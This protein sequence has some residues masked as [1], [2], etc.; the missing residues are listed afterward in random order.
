MDSRQVDVTNSKSTY[1][2]QLKRLDEL[3]NHG[4]TLSGHERNCAFLRSP[5]TESE[6]IPKFGNISSVSGFD[7]PDDAR[8]IALVDWDDDGD[9][10]V[11]VMNRTGPRLRFL[12]NTLDSQNQF[13][14]LQ[15]IGTKS[16]RDAIGTRVSVLPEGSQDSPQSKTLRAGEG[17][18]SQSSKRIHFGLGAVRNA[19]GF[20]VTVRWPSGIKQ[21]FS[22]VAAN[23]FYEL[24]EGDRE[25]RRIADHERAEQSA[26]IR[27]A[28]QAESQ[29][30]TASIFL[31]SRIPAPP[32]RYTRAQ[33]VTAAPVGSG[34]PVLINLWASWCVPC[35]RELVEFDSATKDIAKL[36][37][38]LVALSVDTLP[39]SGVSAADIDSNTAAANRIIESR[40]WSFSM[41]MAA[42]ETVQRLQFL[43]DDLFM[44]K[45][46]IAIP[47]SY[48]L[49]GE[50]RL[51]AIYRGP[52]DLNDLKSHGQQLSL[53]GN[54][55][56]DAALPFPGTWFRPV[57]K[58]TPIRLVNEMA[59]GGNYRDA[60]EYLL[61]HSAELSSQAGY[62]TLAGN[63]GSALVKQKDVERA[64]RMFRLAV[65][66]APT[67]IPV[68]NNLAWYLA[69]KPNATNAE[70]NEALQWATRAAVQTK[71][72]VFPVL[73]TLATAQEELGQNRQAIETLERSIN[74]VD[75]TTTKTQIRDRVK[76]LKQA[77]N[78]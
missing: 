69:T 66:K 41:G 22:N 20:H 15:L 58:S 48:L 13:I 19:D 7:F 2:Q 10:D 26:S 1:R 43:E 34:R 30:E 39:L 18:L 75:D 46:S 60:A 36:G 24:R 5:P 12:R 4:G 45:R 17:F 8:S 78:N 65:G 38:D 77:I 31:A 68:V 52:V 54:E 28:T 9:Q 55:L 29:S 59:R 71:Y 73:D 44:Q 47:T 70:L 27:S 57:G 53:I 63:L 67:N 23:R 16:N 50:G 6:S 33:K 61:K 37:I 74:L 56:Y 64:I 3:I 25:L 21:E 42:Q 62:V 49:D 51:A 40:E 32:I 72:R 11:W 35:Q 14:N 76:K